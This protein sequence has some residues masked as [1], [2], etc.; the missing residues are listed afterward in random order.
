[1][2]VA[3]G[4]EQLVGRAVEHPRAVGAALLPQGLPEVLIAHHLGQHLAGGAGVPVGPDQ[5]VVIDAALD[6]EGLVPGLGQRLAVALGGHAALRR[7][8]AAGQQPAQALP[9]RFAAVAADGQ[10][11]PAQHLFPHCFQLGPEAR[12]VLCF[13]QT[14]DQPVHGHA[15][16]PL[17]Q[18]HLGR[19]APA[20]PQDGVVVAVGDKVLLIVQFQLVQRLRKSRLGL[21]ARQFRLIQQLAQQLHGFVQ[22]ALQQ[23][24]TGG[25]LGDAGRARLPA[26][27]DIGCDGAL[28]QPGVPQGVQLDGGVPAGVQ[29]FQHRGQDGR[30]VHLLGAQRAQVIVELQVQAARR[31]PAHQGQPGQLLSL[32]LGEAGRLAQVSHRQGMVQLELA[33]LPGAGG[34]RRAGLFGHQGHFHRRRAEQFGQQI[35]VPAGAQLA[36]QELEHRFGPQVGHGVAGVQP[37]GGRLDGGQHPVGQAAR[38]LR[39]LEL[40]AVDGGGQ[41]LG[42]D[43]R[44]KHLLHPGLDR[45]RKAGGPLPVGALQHQLDHR[46]LDRAVK[47][48]VDVGPQ[49]LLQQVLF[50]GG[51]VGAQQRVQQDVDGGLLFDLLKAAGVPSQRALHR[52]ALRGLGLINDRLFHPGLRILQGGAGPGRALGHPAQIPL[53]QKGQLF[54]HIHLAVQGDAAVV[55]PVVAAVDLYILLVAQSGDGRRVAP[56]HKAVAV[57]RE[58]GR[59]HRGVQPGFGGGQRPLHLVVHHAAEMAIRLPVPALLLKNAALG[60]GQRAEHRVQVDVHQIA[61]VRLVGG[62]EGVHRLVREG[63]GVEEGRHAALD[64]LHKGRGHGVLFRP[65]QHRVLQ[66]MEHARVVAGE[67]PEPDAERLVLVLVFHQQDGGPAH[68]VGQGGGRPVEQ[69]AFLPPDDGIAGVISYLFAHVVGSPCG[70]CRICFYCIMPRP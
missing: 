54:G 53:V 2:G 63:H 19:E 62:G 14:A 59:V 61:E 58:K 16:G 24:G 48:H 33:L 27:P 66:N 56:G 13:Q 64:Q 17:G 37:A 40:E 3:V 68:V 29:F 5:H 15:A 39:H 70:F 9:G 47:A 67:R 45:R 36:A 52:D 35:I 51:L 21:G 65:R 25:Q 42:G 28:P 26:G 22:V 50:Q 18:G 43:A 8:D 60:H 46:L 12:P 55:G 6:D 44:G 31:R 34:V 30:I 49:V 20:G 23:A 7:K 41:Q 32:C 10:G 1:M 4:V 38:P 57:V 69:G 11:A